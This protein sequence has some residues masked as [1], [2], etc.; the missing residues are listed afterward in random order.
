[1]TG[2]TKGTQYTF[3]IRGFSTKGDLPSNEQSTT[4]G[5]P[6]TM[7]TGSLTAGTR[8]G[9]IG[10]NNSPA[11][12]SIDPISFIYPPGQSNTHVITSMYY[13]PADNW[14]VV[15]FNNS[16]LPQAAENGLKLYVGD[17]AYDLY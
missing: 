10:Y 11:F 1:M 13:T 7:Y 4:P 6:Q 16:R 8:F 17:T 2:L 3:Q 5:P 14:I 9:F 12:G 15:D